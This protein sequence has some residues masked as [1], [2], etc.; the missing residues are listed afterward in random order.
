MTHGFNVVDFMSLP[1]IER[2]IMRTV[3]REVSMTY[4]QLRNA[5]P[6]E[7]IDETKLAETLDD[8]TRN[9]WLSQDTNGQQTHY[10]VRSLQR[11]SSHNNAF[12]NALELDSINQRWSLQLLPQPRQN[13]SSVRSGGKRQLPQCIWDRLAE[14]STPKSQ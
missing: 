1:P 8:L 13:I 7:L 5:I 14:D 11:T 9:H 6:T 2:R 10:R 4:P 12:W 3:L